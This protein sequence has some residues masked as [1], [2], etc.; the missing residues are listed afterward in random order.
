MHANWVLRPSPN[1][2]CLSQRL[3]ISLRN[4][5]RRTS[6]PR[7]PASFSTSSRNLQPEPEPETESRPDNAQALNDD[8]Q[9]ALQ[10]SRHVNRDKQPVRIHY[11]AKSFDTPRNRKV[12]NDQDTS[13]LRR[14]KRPTLPPPDY[15]GQYIHLLHDKYVEDHKLPWYDEGTIS[16]LPLVRLNEELSSFAEFLLPTEKERVARNCVTEDL[17]KIFSMHQ[18]TILKG[19]GLEPFGSEVNSLATI[20]SDLDFRLY[21]KTIYEASDIDAKQAP[22]YNNRKRLINAL[23][24]FQ[25]ALRYLH[26]PNRLGKGAQDHRLFQTPVL[27][28]ARYPLIE[29][30]HRPTNIDVQIVCSNDPSHSLITTSKYMEEIPHI[31]TVYVLLRRTL[32]ARGLTDVFNGGIGS[33]TLFYMIVAALK[34]GPQPMPNTPAEMLL[35]V[36]SFYTVFDSDKKWM[37]IDPP[38]VSEKM[39]PPAESTESR[40]PVGTV[41]PERPYLLSIKDPA[42]PT[43]DLPRQSFAWRHVKATFAVL[44]KELSLRLKT[45]DTR[46]LLVPFVGR[47][48][49]DVIAKREALLK[50]HK[51][52]SSGMAGFDAGLKIEKRTDRQGLRIR[53]IHADRGPAPYRP[54]LRGVVKSD[55]DASQAQTAAEPVQAPNAAESSADE[56]LEPTTTAAAKE[57]SSAAESNASESQ[58]Q[59]QEAAELS[60]E[61][62]APKDSQEEPRDQREA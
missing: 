14:Q 3:R 28:H 8:V 36:L 34:N 37:T 2:N 11:T 13:S 49:E 42:D 19:F 9:A 41:W 25:R 12:R 31:L 44:R 54:N 45:R 18:E 22:R 50:Y 43:N 10:D 35:H 47:F 52:F 7:L 4:P 38:Q 30:S 1:L 17:M 33:Y 32:S 59:H 61:S 53:P 20:T 58:D 57:E 27:L 24:Q 62:S 16:K 6:T 48:F 23:N 39:Q 15:T 21:D 60:L 26:V 56:N 51:V 55:G 46:L 5:P 40:I 29:T